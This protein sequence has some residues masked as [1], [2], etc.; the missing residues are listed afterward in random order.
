MCVVYQKLFDAFPGQWDRIG[1]MA[2]LAY[3]QAH[4]ANMCVA[5]SHAVNG[6]SPVSYTHLDVYKRQDIELLHFVA[7]QRADD[8]AGL[9]ALAEAI[10]HDV[11]V[12]Y[13][14]LYM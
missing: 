14:H 11:P 4:M 3:D 5:Y 6:V 13:T 2:I 8:G 9:F 1:H 10:G 12:S 7:A